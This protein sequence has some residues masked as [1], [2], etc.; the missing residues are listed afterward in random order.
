MRDTKS[1][2]RAAAGLAF[3]AVVALSVLVNSGHADAASIDTRDGVTV[4]QDLFTL[5]VLPPFIK[6]VLGALGIS[7]ED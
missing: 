5:P 1:I 3:S 7:W 4:A 6:G 2:K